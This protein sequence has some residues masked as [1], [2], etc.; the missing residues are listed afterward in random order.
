M[1]IQL[2]LVVLVLVL[3]LIVVRRIGGVRLAIWQI[4]T[5]GAVVMVAGGGLAP[6]E[7]WH[8]IDGDVMLFLFGVFLIGQAL[9]DSGYLQRL[10]YRIFS[11]AAS[12]GALLALVV[13]TSG[14]GS[15]LL[16]N[17]TLAI[18]GTPLMVLLARQHRLPPP[19]LLL[20]LAFAVTTG[21]V[22]SPI[23]NPQNLLIALGAGMANPFVSFFATLA[24]PTLLALAACWLV[25]RLAFRRHFTAAV[26]VHEETPL[27]DASL[28]RL[29]RASLLLLVLLIGARIAVT[30]FNPAWSFPLTWIALG[31]ATPLLLH[32]RRLQLLREL[33]WATLVFFAALFIVMAGVWQSGVLQQLV[34]AIGGSITALPSILFAGLGLSQLISN[35]PL[36]S[37]Y[38]P[39]LL[40]A[41][42]P[43]S[44]LLALAA[45]STLAGNLLVL[46]AASNVI[47]IQNAERDG[48]HIG[49]W[50]FAKVGV[51]LTLV[52]VGIFVPFL[53]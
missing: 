6:R 44:A 9:I 37:L 22:M 5:G 49:Y 53:V 2:P 4:M 20:A 10:G 47:I 19:L 25:L 8:A 26:L 17:D 24:L 15:A 43:Q 33:D 51:L 23:G 48:V 31:A 12:P 11:R 34:G 16:M 3:L 13:F 18:I 36:V 39:L 30:L 42:A 27:R 7:A 1:S 14:L 29:S 40:E 46:G 21:S 32:R 41:Q 50:E 38:L 52:Q 35:V 28:A 45:A